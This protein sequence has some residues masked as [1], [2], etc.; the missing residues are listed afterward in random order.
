MKKHDFW[1]LL[2]TVFANELFIYLFISL[3]LSLSIYIYIYIKQLTFFVNLQN[4]FKLLQ[5]KTNIYYIQI[6]RN[7]ELIYHL[8]YS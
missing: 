7:I 6:I 1:E 4:I 8:K 2:K 3:S 5:Y